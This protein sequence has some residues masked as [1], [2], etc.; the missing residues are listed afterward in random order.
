M[1]RNELYELEGK[2]VQNIDRIKAE[3]AEYING[4]EKGIDLMFRAV[5]DVLAKEEEKAWN[6]RKERE[7]GGKTD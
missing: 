5:R 3:Q 1:T 6:E 2:V 4:V 7:G